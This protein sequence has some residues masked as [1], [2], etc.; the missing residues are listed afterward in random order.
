[1]NHHLPTWLSEPAL[2]QLFTPTHAAGGELRVVGGAVRDFLAQ[3]RIG[4]TAE[5]ILLRGGE[6][7]SVDIVIARRPPE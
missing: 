7:I 6:L 4:D 3:G 5:M 2:Q 1:M